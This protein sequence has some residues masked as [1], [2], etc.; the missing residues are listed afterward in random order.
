MST[1]SILGFIF[2]MEG[3]RNSGV[4]VDKRLNSL[5]ISLAQLSP[6]GEIERAHEL[7]L[8]EAVVRDL[9]DP[10][11]GL[12]AGAIR[13]LAGYGPLTMLLVTCLN[14]WDALNT[15]VRYQALT[16]LFG[17]LSLIPGDKFSALSIRPVPLPP[18]CR[19]F[20]IDRDMVGTYQ[21]IRDLQVNLGI[22]IQPQRVVFPYPKPREYK[23]YE[24]HFGCPVEFDGEEGQI[25]F[26]NE[27]ALIPFP[28]SNRTAHQ[29]YKNQ[30]DQLLQKRETSMTRLC[31]QVAAHLDLFIEDFPSADDVARTFG[32]SE[33]SFRRKLRA[34]TS[35]FRKLL[36]D[37]RYAKAR[38]LLR[39]TSLSIDAVAMMLGYAESAAF[40]HAFQRWAKCAPGE[41]RANLQDAPEADLRTCDR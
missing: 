28:G 41:Y 22:D 30:C 23:L 21:L 10:V 37:V 27:D 40:N 14:P 19:R 36:D 18:A 38:Q 25:V 16:Y 35:S 6:D 8:I 29:M 12:K 32:L 26:R 7:R 20:V 39:D 5:G 3:L 24:Q 11:A 31:E 15:G 2:T 1:R 34:E 33:R 17:T 9:P 13:S 4:D